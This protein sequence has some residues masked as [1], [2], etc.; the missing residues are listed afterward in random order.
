MLHISLLGSPGGSTHGYRELVRR[1]VTG[2]IQGT[3]TNSALQSFRISPI[4]PT[5][6][7]FSNP[8]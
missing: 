6:L 7:D 2:E 4:S 1:S 3:Y 5:I 8:Y